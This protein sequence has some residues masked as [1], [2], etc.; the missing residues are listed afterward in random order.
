MYL[1]VVG[2]VGDGVIVCGCVLVGIIGSGRVNDM[3]IVIDIV[4]GSGRVRVCFM[5][6]VGDMCIVVVVARVS[7]L[8]PVVSLLC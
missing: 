6:S 1:N 5:V 7:P 8:P 3:Y 2:K 4:L